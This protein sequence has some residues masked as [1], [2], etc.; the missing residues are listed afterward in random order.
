[1][2]NSITEKETLK[3]HIMK[4]SYTFLQKNKIE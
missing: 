4:Y 2:S 3:L 1:M